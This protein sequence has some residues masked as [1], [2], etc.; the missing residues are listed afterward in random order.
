[1]THIDQNRL[2]YNSSVPRSKLKGAAGLFC[3]F[4][5]MED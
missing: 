5:L 2:S 3:Q 1:M 4:V